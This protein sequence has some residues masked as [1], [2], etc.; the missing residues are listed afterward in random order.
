LEYATVLDNN[1]PLHP[2]RPPSAQERLAC[3]GIVL[4][5][6]RPPIANFVGGVQQGDLLFLSGQDP[7]TPE[8]KKHG[9]VGR[10][11]TEEEAYRHARLAGL[12][13]LSQMR[14]ILGSRDDWGRG[15]ASRGSVRSSGW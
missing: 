13:L 8:D 10:G 6:A 12:N 4:P 3:A 9:K 11:V 5:A 2:S 14:S 7:V 1:S 15:I